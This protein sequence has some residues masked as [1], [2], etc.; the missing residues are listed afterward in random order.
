MDQKPE[1]RPALIGLTTFFFYFQIVTLFL[2]SG[3]VSSA[4]ALTKCYLP[5]VLTAGSGPTPTPPLA[6]TSSAFAE[7]GTIPDKYTY[8]LSGQCSGQNFSPPLSWTGTPSG[9]QT[10]AITLVDPDAAD[11]V[12]WVQFNIPGQITELPEAVDG[13]AVGIKGIND[14][15]GNGYGGPCPPSGSHH[16]VFTLYALDSTLSLSAGAT[17]AQLDAAMHGHILGQVKLTGVRTP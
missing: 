6:L 17:K 11:F 14:F 9:A 16:Y 13:P 7:G 2:Y 4:S 5:L 8:N 10:L 3:P 12:H 1:K 15:G